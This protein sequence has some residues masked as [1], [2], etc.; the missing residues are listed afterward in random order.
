MY[1]CIL[2]SIYQYTHGCWLVD[3]RS[4]QQGVSRGRY[5]GLFANVAIVHPPIRTATDDNESTPP[6]QQHASKHEAF[7]LIVIYSFY[8][9]SEGFYLKTTSL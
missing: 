7:V 5:G 3:Q 2:Y 4:R 6:A 9:K 8:K 1:I